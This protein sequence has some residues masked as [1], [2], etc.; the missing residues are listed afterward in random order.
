MR[1]LNRRTL[2]GTLVGLG[3]SATG[4][5]VLGSRGRLPSTV[6]VAQ[7][8]R[9]GYLTPIPFSVSPT[10]VEG[11]RQ[12]LREHNWLEKQ[13]I[14][15]QWRSAE[16]QDDRIP[17]LAAELVLLG[18]DVIVAVQSRCVSA[19]QQLTSSI[20]IVMIGVNP[21][22]QGFAASLARPGGNMTGNG[23]PDLSGKKI[24]L[25]RQAMPELSRLAVFVDPNYPPDSASTSASDIAAGAHALN[26]GVQ[27]LQVR[28]PEDFDGAF[29]A[30]VQGRA[31]AL[32]D[33]ASST[34]VSTHRTRIF[35][36]SLKH[37]LAGTWRTT[38]WVQEGGLM[39]YGANQPGQQRRAAGY[40]DRILRGAKP[41]DL[42][43]TLPTEYDLAVNLATARAIGLTVLPDIAAQV[44]EWI[45]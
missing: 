15:I 10:N 32:M 13:N 4:L 37:K 5:V 24:E 21:V 6:P 29:A 1:T 18:L 41:A 38:Q 19:L 30:A 26:I 11:F 17:Q 43:I 12:G 3:A 42:P 25:L 33:A 28:L 7:G 8:P 20:P 40:V 34:L 36:F 45:E 16:G 14:D 22:V 35:D 27:W 39:A 44:T 23:S 31:E 2:I 9:I